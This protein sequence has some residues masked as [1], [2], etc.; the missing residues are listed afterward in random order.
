MNAKTLYAI[1]DWLEHNSDSHIIQG[2]QLLIEIPLP[3]I[4]YDRE[5]KELRCEGRT[6]KLR[7]TPTPKYPVAYAGLD[8]AQAICEV[9]GL[10]N[11]GGYLIGRGSSWR[12][13]LYEIRRVAKLAEPTLSD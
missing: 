9:L 3:G 13:Y 6:V 7:V 10:G 1:A 2:E 11:P 8:L 4:E 5:Q 12:N